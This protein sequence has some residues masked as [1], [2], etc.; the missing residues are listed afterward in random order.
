F[1]PGLLEGVHGA[2]SHTYYE[3]SAAIIGL[4]LLG[5]WLEARA[6][7]RTSSAVRALVDLRPQLA[8]VIEDNEPYEIPVRAVQA[9]DV[10]LVRPSEQIPVDGEVIEGTSSVDES[11]LTGESVPVSKQPG[12]T[13]FGATMNSSGLLRI[14]ATAVGADSALARIIRLVEEAQTSKAPIQALADRIA[15]IFVPVVLGIAALTF[16]GWWAFGPEPAFT[17]AFVNAVTVLIIACPCAL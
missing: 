7:G 11:M 14:R 12:D 2:E 9:G 5:R 17:L 6:K 4:V 3:A 16:A 8:R 15:G 13:V 1:A 10:V